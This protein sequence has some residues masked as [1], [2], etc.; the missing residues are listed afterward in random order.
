MSADT[1]DLR[2]A[3]V[4]TR[5]AAEA[6]DLPGWDHAW[7]AALS[8][9]E[10]AADEAE[11]LLSLAHLPSTTEVAKVAA[12][13]PP[14]GLGPL[15]LSL[16]E[17]AQALVDRQLDLARRTAEAARM[18]RRQARVADVLAT[19]PPARPVYLDAEG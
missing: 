8:E 6:A 4:V 7:S 5:P 13:R 19:R 17:R 14:H 1:V 10:L 9:L 2:P 3:P 18:S 15:P 12:W 11:R 16:R